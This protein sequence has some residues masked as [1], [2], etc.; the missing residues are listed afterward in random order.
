MEV[1]EGRREGGVAAVLEEAAQPDLDPGAVAERAGARRPRAEDRRDLVLVEVGADQCVDLGIAG[2][3]D[4]GDEVADAERVDA[5]AQ[6]A[7]RLHLVAL[8][9]RDVAHVVAE[10][11]DPASL[12]VALGR[13]RRASSRR[14]A[15]CTSGSVQCPTT[16]VRSSR[17]RA[18]MNP[19][20]RS[21]C[22][23]WLRFMKS[24]SM[25]SHGIALVVLGVQM[26]ERSLQ[27]VQPGDPH[28]R[29]RER[30]HPGDHADARRCGV[31]LEH[32]RADPL[33]VHDDR[34]HDDPYRDRRRGVEG[35][36]D[37]ASPVRATVCERLRAIQVLAAGD[38]PDFERGEIWHAMDS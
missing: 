8:G 27:S 17:I 31:R 15:A 30:V 10:A 2:G 16:T 5:E 23:A 32:D 26:Q 19:N 6:P 24:M 18:A 14:S 22:A 33:G 21:P 3:V 13:T 37:L 12:P 9:D 20:S 25:P 7:L 11:G 38:E 36:R 34:L 35:G 28:L 1:L 4:E 29:G